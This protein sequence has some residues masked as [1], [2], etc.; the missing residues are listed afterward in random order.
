MFRLVLSWFAAFWAALKTDEK[1]PD[2]VTGAVIVPPGVFASSICG[3]K[4]AAVIVLESLLEVKVP[5][6]LRR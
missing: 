2:E 6:L 1:K 3:V 4:G 5:A